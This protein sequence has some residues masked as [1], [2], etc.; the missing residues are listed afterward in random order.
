M[1]EPLPPRDVQQSKDLK[2]AP[3]AVFDSGVGGISVLREMKRLLPHEDFIYFG[4]ARNT[5]YGEKESVA[6]RALIFGHAASLLARAKALV[7][8]C[9]TATAVA[10]K[11]LRAAYPNVPIIGMEPAVKPALAVGNHPRILI[12]ATETTL[13]EK[14]LKA[15]L[16]RY[17]SHA[18]FL[19]LAAPELVRLIEA[20]KT[21][22]PD[23]DA[24]LA[25]LLAP[26]SGNPPDAI[27]LGCTH[28]PL[29][30]SAISRV[31]SDT[32]PL[33]HGAEGTAKELKRRLTSANLL[34]EQIHL[35]TVTLT[36][37]DS[38]ALPRYLSLFSK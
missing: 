16:A 9:N 31:F 25:A 27:V 8:A 15:L 14:K 28:F 11:A 19:P 18:T 12:L 38:A 24:Y 2:N 30:A 32:V 29:A 26:F 35:G 1:K 21:D 22:S 33:F 10:V 13:R 4:D 6:L 3:V 7:L 23:L 5:P 20:G 37:S 34:N 36:A 17:N